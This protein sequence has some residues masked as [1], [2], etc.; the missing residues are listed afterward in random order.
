MAELGEPIWAPPFPNGWSDLG[1][2]WA[3]PSQMMLRTN[4]ANTFCSGYQHVDPAA[5][6]QTALGPLISPATAA[7]IG[8]VSATHDKLTILFCSPDF[9]RR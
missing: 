1:A 6:M 9:Q 5:I 8:R 2:D 3:S 4:W 7:M